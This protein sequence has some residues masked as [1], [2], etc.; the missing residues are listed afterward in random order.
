LG[1]AKAAPLAF[2]REREAVLR[3]LV[4][5]FED[6]LVGF[7]ILGLD[8][9]RLS[10]NRAFCEF[11]GYPLDEVMR[12]G[13]HDLVHPEDLEEDWRQFELLLAGERDSYRREKRLLHRDG[14]VIW[15]DF[16]CR[17]ARD[18][19]GE[20][21]FFITQVLDITDRKLAGQQ[22]RDMGAMLSLAAQVGR[23]GAWA[24]DVGSPTLA[25]SREA[26]AIYEARPG[27]TPT[28][29]EAVASTVR[30]MRQQL[31]DTLRDCTRT[32]SPFDIEVEAVT[33]RGRRIWV[34]IIC[35]AEWDSEGNVRRLQGAVQDITESRAA[36]QEVL[37]L[38]AEL[39]ERVHQR[40]SQLEA[41]NREL[42]SF[43]YSIAHDLRAPLGSI[44]GFSNTLEARAG[45]TLDDTSRH[46]LRRIRAGVQQMSGLT[47]GLLALAR[48]SRSELHVAAVDLAELARHTEMHLRRLEPHR[49]VQMTIAPSL[50][51]MGDA[52]LLQKVM[53]QLIG[54]AWKFTCRRACAHI[55]VGALQGPQ[56]EWVYFVRDDG[57]G[58][59][60]AHASKMFEAFH[61]LHRADEFPGMGLGL[62][63]A[64]RIVTRHR[65]RIWGESAPDRGATFYFTLK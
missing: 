3:H 31:R 40:T 57:A 65:G 9:T 34:R 12:L 61:R 56:G 11:T 38:N 2:V 42:E 44:D 41:A 37:R 22:L 52:R 16:R 10:C 59:D 5:S 14:R 7:T 62:A 54:N 29:H 4:E 1:N 19:Q 63:I 47:D 33:Q 53:S 30:E 23:L 6:A 58:F 64:Q 32:G 35:E 55:E 48:L 13:M 27:A 20:P 50:P 36:R 17:L 21:L 49:M 15:A 18:S 43:S 39:E 28:P 24:W 45:A 46:Y 25:C 8:R 51:A 26:C 60:M